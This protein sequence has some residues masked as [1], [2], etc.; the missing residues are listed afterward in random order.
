[1][2]TRFLFYT[3]FF[4]VSS[5]AWSLDDW[6]EDFKKSATKEQL[7]QFLYAMPKGGDLH[8]HLSGA[9]LSEWW[10]E[11]ATDEKINGGYRYY[12]KVKIANCNGYGQNEFGMTPYLMR[13]VNLQESSYNKL[14]DCQKS[15]YAPISELND[16]QKLAWLDSI[17]LD[18]PY[19]GRDEFF[20]THWQRLS[21]L[22]SNPYAL[23]EIMVKNMQTFGA[24]GL[25]YI[26]FQHGLFGYIDP[27]GNDFDPEA[28]VTLFTERL[29]QDDALATGVTVRL[30]L[31]ILRFTPVAEQ[32]MERAY[33]FLDA[34][35]DLYVGLNMVGR[36]DNDKGYPARFLPTLRKLRKEM[37][38]V[39]LSF[40]AGEVDE[41]NSHVRDSLLLGAH[42]IGHGVNLISDPDTMLLMR[43]GDN[44]VEINLV[45]NLLLEYISDYDQH[46]FPEYLRFGI[47]VALSTDD[48]GMWD[49]NM[50]DEFFTAVD[51]FNLSW[52]E[53]LTLSRNSISHAFLDT[54]NKA[55]ILAKY[56]KR[57][58]KFEKKIQR[59][60]MKA[61][62]S[63]E[64]ISYSHACKTFALCDYKRQ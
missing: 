20:Q 4:L 46:P 19:E 23:A 49:S 62:S 41:P 53:I 51:N 52:Q 16:E 11:L 47:P 13:F 25:L 29:K 7:Y 9:G 2:A 58:S 17:R 8:N 55:K 18:K 64:P 26:E 54:E 63:V 40:H 5:N 56:N 50:T 60:G 15:E 1:M 35:R 48:R 45:S 27:A 32:A 34:H 37:P 12:T 39:N 28:I 3:I 57:I 14:D 38:G 42:R 22:G 43:N 44:L 24:E 61:L 36:E 6:F 21:D 31:S 33:R 30:Q 10:Y 59:S